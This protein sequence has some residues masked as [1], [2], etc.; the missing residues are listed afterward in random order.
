[1]HA[2]AAGNI[3]RIEANFHGH[4][5][6][7]HR[8]DTYAL[9]ITVSGVQT[10]RYRGA[11]R[12]SLPG[13]VIVLHPDEVHD[14]SAGTDDGLTYRMLYLP[15]ERLTEAGGGAKGLPFVPDPIVADHRFRLC[16]AEA[17]DDLDTQ[18]EALMLD[19][20]ILRLGA[21]LRRN[22][23]DLTGQAAHQTGSSIDRAAMLRCRDYLR[24]HCDRPVSSEELEAVSGLDRYQTAR[25]FRRLFGTSPHRYLVMRRLDRAK[26]ALTEDV[27]LAQ[28]ALDSGFAD[29]AHFTRHFKKTFGMTPGR[30]T[31][32]R[33]SV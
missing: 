5:F 31:A 6:E 23:D 4:G 2:P 16:L 20:L 12:A 29:Q 9:G 17:L 14:G 27:G 25:Q 19:D 22:S 7:P 18:P 30:W 3:E 32:L 8:H 10:F 26:A 15:P 21:A 11:E 28:A 33:R 1:M 24:E 13:N